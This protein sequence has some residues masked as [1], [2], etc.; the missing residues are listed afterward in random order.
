MVWETENCNFSSVCFSSTPRSVQQATLL[1]CSV[2]ESTCWNSGGETRGPL[3]DSHGR[4]ARLH[5]NSDSNHGLGQFRGTWR[6]HCEEQGTCVVLGCSTGCRGVRDARQETQEHGQVR[7]DFCIG[8][9]ELIPNK[10]TATH[11]RVAAFPLELYAHSDASCLRLF[12]HTLGG[13]WSDVGALSHTGVGLLREPDATAEFSVEA[14][15]HSTRSRRRP[16]EREQETD[17][18]PHGSGG[19]SLQCYPL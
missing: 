19:I 17:I 16:P 3:C 14:M 4:P 15:A 2:C 12:C 11:T 18:T 9:K 1:T 6:D 5:R 7:R 13:G 10:F 8:E